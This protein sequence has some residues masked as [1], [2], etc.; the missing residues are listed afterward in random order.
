MNFLAHCVLAGPGDGFLAG[1]V[2][3][4]FVKGRI[5]DAMPPELR[6][7]VRLHRRI[8]SFSN[9]L[10]EMKASVRR[11]HPT[12]RRPA[13]VLLDLVADHCL[14]LGWGHHVATHENC[15]N[16]DAFANEVY[17]ALTR[18]RE[19]VPAGGRRFV[20]YLVKTALLS[21]YGDP[22]IIHR[23]MAQALERL[24]FHDHIGKLAPVLAED[25]CGFRKDFAAYFPRL[26]EFAAAERSRIAAWRPNTQPW[27]ATPP[28]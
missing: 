21:R 8:D 26:R 7:G 3:G 1:A 22:L 14:A 18:M 19:W 12:L 11:F 4:D 23:A 25:L 24:G 10:A 9:G 28:P 27:E 2:L 13:P 15:A 16:L 17:A 20:D 6:A 5:P